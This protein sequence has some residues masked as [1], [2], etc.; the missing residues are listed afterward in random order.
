MS[1]LTYYVISIIRHTI[2]CSKDVNGSSN[3]HQAWWQLS[4]QL[5]AWMVVSW[6]MLTFGHQEECVQAFRNTPVLSSLQNLCRFM[7]DLIPIMESL[8]IDSRI[9]E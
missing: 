1:N 8:T 5:T 7:I 6:S 4:D 9:G 2:H 3:A